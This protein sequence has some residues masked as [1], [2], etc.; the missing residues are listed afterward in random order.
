MPSQEQTTCSGNSRCSSV[1]LLARIEWN[2]RGQPDTPARR[3]SRVISVRRFEFF[4]PIA[5]LAAARYCGA[6]TTYSLLSPKISNASSRIG[7]YSGK[8][9]VAANPASFMML[10]FRLGDIHP[11]H[12]PVDVVPAKRQRFRWSPKP[13]VATRHHLLPTLYRV[14]GLRLLPRRF[15]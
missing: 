5:V 15:M 1:C 11:I 9:R 4:Q 6:A 10:D 8:D 12:L 14:A 2:K 3:S 7:R 13:A